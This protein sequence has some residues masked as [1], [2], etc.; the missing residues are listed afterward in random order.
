MH[1][2]GAAGGLGLVAGQLQGARLRENMCDNSFSRLLAIE[3]FAC[4]RPSSRANWSGTQCQ[5]MAVRS[6]Q[7]VPGCDTDV[8]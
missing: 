7:C 5:M 8:Q 6:V 3:M 4:R 1:L 2:E